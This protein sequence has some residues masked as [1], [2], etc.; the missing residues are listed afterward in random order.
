MEV[1]LK[2]EERIVSTIIRENRVRVSRG[3]VSF[4]PAGSTSAPEGVTGEDVKSM[5]ETIEHKDARIE[6]LMQEVDALKVALEEKAC[7]NAPDVPDAK[8]DVE[9]N[10][11][12]GDET[13]AKEVEEA[14]TTEAPEDGDKKDAPEAPDAKEVEEVKDTK[15]KKSSKK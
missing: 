8:D 1:I 2:G 3:Q 9:E 13:D 6:E 14:D 12:E 5:A 11:G 4:S 10:D 7:T 15:G